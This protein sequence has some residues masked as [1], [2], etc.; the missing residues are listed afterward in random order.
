M[1]R[2]TSLFAFATILASLA[3]TACSGGNLGQGGSSLPTADSVQ[4]VSD[5]ADALVARRTG[6]QNAKESIQATNALGARL[7]NLSSVGVDDVWGSLRYG[8]ANVRRGHAQRCQDRVELFAPDRNGDPNSTEALFFYDVHCTQVALDDVRTYTST[9]SNSETVNHTDSLYPPGGATA[10][11]THSGTTS[12]SN[13]TIGA[14]GIPNAAAGFAA[15]SSDQVTVN[16]NAVVKTSSEFVM[17]PGSQQMSTFCED[18]AGYDPSGIASLDATFGWQGG[19]LSGGTRSTNGSGF[20]S[21]SATPSGTVYQ[22]AIGGLSIAGGTQNVSCPI[23][24]PDFSLAGG[25]S[26]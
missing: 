17:M 11:A 26:V 13:A 4:T 5:T 19:I 9:G 24:T 16:A 18:S 15:V 23:A 3:L 2:P 20:T 6:T 7:Q 25:T 10:L 1:A 12:I 8:A 22:G 14:Y 21:W